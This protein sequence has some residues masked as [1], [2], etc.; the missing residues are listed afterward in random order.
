[1]PQM[2]DLQAVVDTLLASDRLLV[3]THENPDGDA[4]GSL[5]ATTVALRQLGKDVSMYLAGSAPL[6]R[7][8]GFMQLDGLL[9]ELPADAGERV[10][11]AV[12]C[13]KADRIGPDPA[14]VE[15][16]KLVVNIDHHHDNTRFGA[17]NLIVEI[18]RAHV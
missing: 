8:Y 2:T 7:E 9:R 3:V 10:L 16:T 12:D 11:V 5:V 18:G 1:M 13:A 6:P 14:P 17:V 15:R 4:L